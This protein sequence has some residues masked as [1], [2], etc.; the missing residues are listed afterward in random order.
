MKTKLAHTFEL[1]RAYK[2]TLQP[3]AKTRPSCRKPS[4]W[5]VRGA[6]GNATYFGIFSFK[7]TRS[8]PTHQP[9]SQEARGR[10]ADLS[11][12]AKGYRIAEWNKRR[13]Y[14]QVFREPT[15]I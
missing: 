7:P 9:C 10:I 8:P 15:A 12:V 13:P 5:A 1:N 6:S 11:E 3:V 4:G 2:C 14:L